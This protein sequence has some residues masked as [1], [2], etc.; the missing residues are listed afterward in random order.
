[1]T[2]D[3]TSREYCTVRRVRTNTPLQALA[4]LNDEAFFEAAQALARACSPTA[5]PARRPNRAP[6]SASAS[7]RRA[8]PTQPSFR[9]S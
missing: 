8:S 1:M 6:P 2:F 4:L 7:S 5:P 9:A 3:A